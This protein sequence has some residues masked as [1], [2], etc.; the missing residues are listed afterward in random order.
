MTPI[1]C[2]KSVV[3]CLNFF[4]AVATCWVGVR[5]GATGSSCSRALRIDAGNASTCCLQ[6]TCKSGTSPGWEEGSGSSVCFMSFLCS[7]AHTCHR[8]FRASLSHFPTRVGPWQGRRDIPRHFYGCSGGLRQTPPNSLEGLV[9]F[10]RLVL[11]RLGCGSGIPPLMS[12]FPLGFLRG[13]PP[14]TVS[15]SA[16]AGRVCGDPTVENPLPAFANSSRHPVPRCAEEDA[17]CP[18]Y[19]RCDPLCSHAMAQERR[20]LGLAP[21][22]GSSKTTF[23]TKAQAQS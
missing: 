15:L 5:S 22:A 12:I 9:C 23:P 13:G 14:H 20:K 8:A 19:R 16:G 10:V 17:G 4:A 18:H 11:L 7:S 21:K 2:L 1:S 6:K 3:A